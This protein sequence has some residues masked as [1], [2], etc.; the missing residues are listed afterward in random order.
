VLL[1]EP[2]MN[3]VWAW[4]VHRERP[5]NWSLAG[6]AIIVLATLANTW[7]ARQGRAGTLVAR[8]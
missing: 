7:L 6:G 3:P 5:A 2:V 4:L 1:L 8:K